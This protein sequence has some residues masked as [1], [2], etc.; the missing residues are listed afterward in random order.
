MDWAIAAVVLII[1]HLI[2]MLWL[3]G[4]GAALCMAALDDLDG[5]LAEAIRS[6][7]ESGGGE[8]EPVN[9]VQAAIAQFITTR[10]N[11]PVIEA[12]VTERGQDGK[13]T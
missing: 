11:S 13:F 8:F 12:V 7:L 4:K 3:A 9:P 2:V 10:M 1:F 5:K 6:V